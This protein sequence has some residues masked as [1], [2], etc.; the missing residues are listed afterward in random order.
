MFVPFITYYLSCGW[1]PCIYLSFIT[2]ITTHYKNTLPAFIPFIYPLM[3]ESHRATQTLSLLRKTLD[4]NIS[5]FFIADTR[6]LRSLYSSS[7]ETSLHSSFRGLGMFPCTWIQP[8][9]RS[10][11]LFVPLCSIAIPRI[12][13]FAEIIMSYQSL[14]YAAGSCSLASSSLRVVPLP[15][16]LSSLSSLLCIIPPARLPSLERRRGE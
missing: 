12:S 6:L 11:R 8:S 13:F 16:H 9:S 14:R 3:I 4:I 5:A 1:S 2:S 15:T 7:S 10:N